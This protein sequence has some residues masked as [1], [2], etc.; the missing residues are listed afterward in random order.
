MPLPASVVLGIHGQTDV[1]AEKK[2]RS[3]PALSEE[4][5]FTQY[6]QVA[7]ERRADDTRQGPRIRMSAL[8]ARTA[9]PNA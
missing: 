7:A 2:S 4:S 6:P 1:S 5:R 3:L 8:F 9:L